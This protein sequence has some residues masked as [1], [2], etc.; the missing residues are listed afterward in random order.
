MHKK[1]L[2]PLGR[3]GMKI[4]S[5]TGLLVLAAL[6]LGGSIFAVAAGSQTSAD[7]RGRN[8]VWFEA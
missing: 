4:Y 5:Q 3:L 8:W 6:V 1:I 2:S 7:L